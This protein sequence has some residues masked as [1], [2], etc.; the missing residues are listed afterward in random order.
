M[1]KRLA[2]L[3]L[4][5]VAI[6]ASL[7]FGFRGRKDK[8]IQATSTAAAITTQAEW[9]L[10]TKSNLLTTGGTVS[11]DDKTE[12]TYSLS[13]LYS[14]SPGSFTT[15]TGTSPAAGFDGST[16]TQWY[17]AIYEGSCDADPWVIIDLAEA[18]YIGTIYSFSQPMDAWYSNNGTD[19]TYFAQCVDCDS[20]TYVAWQM[21]SHPT[22]RYLRLQGAGV[23]L[24]E[25][26][27]TEH[28][29]ATHTTGATQ[30][31][32]GAN[33]FDWESITPTQTVPAN[34]SITYRYRSS[35]NGTDWNAWHSSF[36]DVES[37]SGDTKYRYLQ[38]EATLSNTDGTSTPTIDQYSIGYHTNLAPSTP[39]N[40]TAVVG[41]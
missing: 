24:Y 25:A 22:A 4:V 12:S 30:I 28:A 11:I 41:E 5:F 3:T 38:V 27:F 9:D 34:T 23:A 1:K 2:V 14:S 37:I 32:G 6:I 40:L 29:S 18:T 7:Y 39:T 36:G 20:A 31:D 8:P 15:C 19:Y 33:F 17:A 13:N 35:A 16:A 26:Y 10:G 21:N